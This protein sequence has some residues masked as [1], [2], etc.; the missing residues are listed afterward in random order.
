MLISVCVLG[1]TELGRSFTSEFKQ[2][3]YY[4]KRDS[5][6]EG[7]RVHTT[8]V[9]DSFLLDS[10]LVYR[11]QLSDGNYANVLN[12]GYQKTKKESSI[13]NDRDWL[14]ES[15]GHDVIVEAVD[16][17]D[18][19]LETLIHLI[20]KGYRTYIT[21]RAYADKYAGILEAAA[22]EGRTTVTYCDTVHNVVG[23][24][25]EWYSLKL[26]SQRKNLLEDSYNAP[27]CGLS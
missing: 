24:L 27:P 7:V 1:G 22:A 11:Y 17:V 2:L 3:P 8:Y 26:S 15:N 9:D 20:K 19:Y 12:D 21:S 13:G 5:D 14:F 6:T 25:D 4:K 16:D 23:L 18:K 10:D